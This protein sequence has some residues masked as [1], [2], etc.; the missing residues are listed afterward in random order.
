MTG[1]VRLDSVDVAI[2]RELQN[3]GRLANKALAERVGVAPSTCLDRVSRLRSTGV[4]TGFGTSVSPAGV[5]RSVEAFLAVQMR[6]HTRRGFDPFVAHVRGLPE[7]VSLHFVTGPDDFIVR[8]ACAGSS[9]LQRLVL[10]EF[11]S[12]REVARVQTHLIF[13]S[14]AGG[15]LL[16]PPDQG[17]RG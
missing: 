6:V 3:D 4:I 2:L 9:D 7:T 16:P 17:T 12:R 5:G 8:V 11:T 13:T 10:D 1:S 14:W 15:P